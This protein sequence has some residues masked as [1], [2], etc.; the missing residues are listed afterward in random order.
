M[1]DLVAIDYRVSGTL[2]GAQCVHTVRNTASWSHVPILALD[3]SWDEVALAAAYGSGVGACFETPS[4][5]EA[6]H[7][8]LT[9]LLD[10]WGNVAVLPK[11]R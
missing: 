9:A 6:L 7:Q 11:P 3:G 5:P 8:L 10:F 2:D 1:P 4:T